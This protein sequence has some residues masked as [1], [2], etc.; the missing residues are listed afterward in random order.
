MIKTLLLTF[1][2]AMIASGCVGTITNK[3]VAQ[4]STN[5]REN[6]AVH[7]AKGTKKVTTYKRSIEEKDTSNR[8]RP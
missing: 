1:L 8:T 5:E 2:L 7:H 3:N 4:G 6:N